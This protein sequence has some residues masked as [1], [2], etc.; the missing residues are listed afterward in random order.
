MAK[1]ITFASQK[2]GVGKTT[3]SVH[4]ATA[5]ALG[6]YKTL[7]VDLDPQGSVLHSLSVKKHSG[8]GI[9]EIFCTPNTSLKEVVQSSKH[10]NLDLLLSNIEDLLTEQTVNNIAADY[11]HVSQW[12]NQNAAN[13]YDFV[14][15]DSPASTNSLSINAMLAA[16]LIIVPLECETLAIKSLKRFLQAFKELQRAIE[17]RLRLAGILLTMFDKD[18]LS[19]RQVCKQICQTLGDSVFETIIPN[20]PHIL[21]ASNLGIDVIQRHLNSEG[22]T[23]Y[24][25]LA[26]EL[27]DRF[28]L[29]NSY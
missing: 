11:Y 8:L 2:G 24:I 26:N 15:V 6:G 29:P 19:H 17:P 1:V 13:T 5:F 20:C 27:L 12:M 3:S 21:E 22:A 10:Q 28:L 25:R 23:G 4:L 18:I 7:L 16:D 14:I 9:R